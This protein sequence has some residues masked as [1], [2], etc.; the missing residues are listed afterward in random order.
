MGP[1]PS[2]SLV[3]ILFGCALLT[4]AGMGWFL[5]KRS[6]VAPAAEPVQGA[7]QR[8]PPEKRV[9]HL[10]FGD[11]QGRYLKAEQRVMALPQDDVRRSRMLMESLF[12][13]PQKDGSRT[14]PEGT[15]LRSC[16]I[17]EGG[18]AYVVLEQ[19]PLCRHP[20]GVETELL[21]IYSI[22]NTLVL[23][24]ETVRSVKLLI[25]G[26]EAATLAGHV[27]LRHAFKADMLWIR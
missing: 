3:L 2:R 16:F 4:A 18:T 12:A 27:D 19:E 22:V 6:V 26:H 11:H 17:T 15:R 8:R 14:F 20:G 7:S 13:G 10:Y 5:A 23:N 1:P 24:L 21:S 25:G 9:V